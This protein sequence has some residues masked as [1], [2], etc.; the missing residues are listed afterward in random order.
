[1]SHQEV[2]EEPCLVE[3]TKPYHVIYTLHRGGVHG[4]D[5]A[6]RLLVDLVLLY[7]MKEL[8]LYGELTLISLDL[9]NANSC[10]VL[11][12]SFIIDQLKLSGV[13]HADLRPDLHLAT[14]VHPHKIP[15]VGETRNCNEKCSAEKA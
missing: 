7:V 1:M 15:L 10:G 4:T 5:G 11:Y 3:I 13:C 9:K 6:L 8:T 12:L 14:G 2:P